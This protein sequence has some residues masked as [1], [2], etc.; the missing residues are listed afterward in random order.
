MLPDFKKD[1]RMSLRCSQ[2]ITLIS[3]LRKK[4]TSSKNREFLNII[5]KI[6]FLTNAMRFTAMLI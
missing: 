5:T 4:E 1:D 2:N 3:Y 6:W